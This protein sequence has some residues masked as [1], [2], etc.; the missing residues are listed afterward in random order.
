MLLNISGFLTDIDFHVYA[1]HLAPKRSSHPTV[2]IYNFI[3]GITLRVYLYLPR[4]CSL[5]QHKK[6]TTVLPHSPLSVLI[7][8]LVLRVLVFVFAPVLNHS[9][10]TNYFK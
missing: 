5:V 1:R 4:Q 7:L 9:T 10:V 2:N 8:F 6:I 3:T